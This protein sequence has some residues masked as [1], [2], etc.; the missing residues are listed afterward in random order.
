MG[1]Q[2]CT[3]SCTSRKRS[4]DVLEVSISKK[5]RLSRESTSF[6]S[7]IVAQFHQAEVN[8]ESPT[9]IPR[10]RPEKEVAVQEEQS[11]RQSVYAPVST[12]G[13]KLKEIRESEEAQHQEL[14][15][16][17]IKV[18]RY[19]SR[20]TIAVP[21]SDD[22][23]QYNRDDP[24][25]QEALNAHLYHIGVKIPSALETVPVEE[26]PEEKE[27]PEEEEDPEEYSEDE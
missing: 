10:Q 23:V 25:E 4:H 3:F 2:V 26:N 7:D 15:R 12:F 8:V 11:R 5:P 20:D 9:C 6:Q 24:S 1:Q 16:K 18:A 21:Q 17:K 27:D 19:L 13:D 14:D 22:R